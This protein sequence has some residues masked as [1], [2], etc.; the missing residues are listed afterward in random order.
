MLASEVVAIPLSTANLLTAR[1]KPEVYNHDADSY[2]ISSTHITFNQEQEWSR[3]SELGF[4]QRS[5]VQYHWENPGYGTFEDFLG[6][7]KGPKRKNIRQARHCLPT[8]SDSQ[9]QT[10]ARS[11]E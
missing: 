4:L 1:Q 7:L 2:N 11:S 6:T 10:T 9:L 3:L 8:S 5:G